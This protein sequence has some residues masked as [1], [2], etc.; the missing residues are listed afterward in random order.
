EDPDVIGGGEISGILVC[1][2]ED[3]HRIRR[4]IIHRRG[5]KPRAW[6][7]RP[8]CRGLRNLRTELGPGWAGSLLRLNQL[9]E[10]EH[11]YHRREAEKPRPDPSHKPPPTR[12]AICSKVAGSICQGY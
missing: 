10:T 3:D 2:P 7:R 6:H 4:W 8:S 1:P 12:F 9:A 11:N 5:E